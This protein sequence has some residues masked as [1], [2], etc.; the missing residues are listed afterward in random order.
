MFS[1]KLL[2]TKI[3][4]AQNFIDDSNTKK[5]FFSTLFWDIINNGN[6]IVNDKGNGKGN[7]NSNGKGFPYFALF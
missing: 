4:S 5:R 7:G 3:I 6:G 2:R 1:F